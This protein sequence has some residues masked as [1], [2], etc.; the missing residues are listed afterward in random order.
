MNK[1]MSAHPW[2]TLAPYLINRPWNCTERLCCSSSFRAWLYWPRKRTFC[3]SE[4]LKRSLRRKQ[5]SLSGSAPG[6]AAGTRDTDAA[7]D[8]FYR[9]TFNA[10]LFIPSR[11][12]LANLV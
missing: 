12:R 9:F 1:R 5:G 8:L 11:L 6:L 3:S 2:Q 4:S 10:P 7:L